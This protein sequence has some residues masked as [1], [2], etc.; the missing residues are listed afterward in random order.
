MFRKGLEET[1]QILGRVDLDHSE[2]PN[3]RVVPTE[4]LEAARETKSAGD[5]AASVIALKLFCN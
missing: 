3:P 2:L 5:R 1:R 4:I